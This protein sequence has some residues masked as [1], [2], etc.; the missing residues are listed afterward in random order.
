MDPKVLSIVAAIQKRRLAQARDEAERAHLREPLA[1]VEAAELAQLLDEL[2]F[3]DALA[4][5][6]SVDD[7]AAV[8]AAA[9]LRC[10]RALRA[11]THG[12]E[13]AGLAEWEAVLAAYPTLSFPYLSRG[14][15]WLQQKEDTD[16]AL[17]DFERAVAVEP[18][19]GSVR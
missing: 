18:G 4:Q 10:A 12:D 11:C 14:R 19:N 15:W 13:P 7:P 8:E 6:A 17:A 9:A 1:A 5:L 2:D 3:D 16:R